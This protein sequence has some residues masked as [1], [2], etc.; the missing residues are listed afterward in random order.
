[1]PKKLHLLNESRQSLG[2]GWSFLRNFKAGLNRINTDWELTDNWQ[3]ANAVLLPGAT[4]ATRE[5][6]KGIKA[7][8]IPFVL[9][10][11]NAPRNSRNRNSG[12]SRLKDFANWADYVVFQSKWAVDYLGRFLGSNVGHFIYNGIDTRIFN[13]DGIKYDFKGDPVYLYSRYSRDE[14]KRWEQAWWNYQMIQ[15]NNSEAELVIV[16]K[17]SPDL[18]NYKF[19]F[20]MEESY[21]YLGVIDTPEEMAK[22]YRGCD[23]LLATYSNDCYSNTYLEA[24]ACGVKLL[25]PDISGGTSEMIRNGVRDCSEMVEEYLEVIDELV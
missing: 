22:I 14:T 23:Y 17:F 15:R 2:G 13:I 18:V 9:R 20:F 10:V 5:T 19:D 1:M 25:E 24:L 21:Q 6:V 12:T 8:N 16:G 4:M 7:N 11:D 3:D